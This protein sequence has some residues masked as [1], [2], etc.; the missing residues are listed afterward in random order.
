MAPRAYRSTVRARQSAQTREAILDGLAAALAA[1]DVA[2]AT[3]AQ[4]AAH[5]GVGEATVYRHF[6]TRQAL[7]DAFAARLEANGRMRDDGTDV[8]TLA[9]A[10]TERFAFFRQ[11]HGLMH[12]VNDTAPL[13][14][15]ADT[16]RARRVA[17]LRAQ[18]AAR[19][20]SL[21]EA[22]AQ[23][24]AVVLQHVGGWLGWSDLVDGADLDDATAA[25]V[26]AWALRALVAA[27]DGDDPLAPPEEER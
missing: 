15:L 13:R 5:A 23:G 26:T 25:R 2:D 4:V 14:P 20:P 17:G 16:M 8:A 10:T 18:L 21:S 19:H 22:E 12:A 6:A 7:F 1:P 24:V 27:L 9:A 11:H 3:I